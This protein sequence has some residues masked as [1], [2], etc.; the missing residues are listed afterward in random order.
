MT[1]TTTLLLRDAARA[2][3][4]RAGGTHALSAAIEIVVPSDAFADGVDRMA[5]TIDYD[6]VFAAIAAT[7]AEDGPFETHEFIAARIAKRVLALPPAEGVTVTLTAEDWA[8][9]RTAGV[10]LRVER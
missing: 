5:A 7:A 3:P 8:P 9:G 10:R 1:P 4:M 2:Y 6:A